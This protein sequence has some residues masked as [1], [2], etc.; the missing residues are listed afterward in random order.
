M[1]L[2]I[3]FQQ[4][5]RILSEMSANEKNVDQSLKRSTKELM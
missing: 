1:Y 5:S 4:Y 3:Y 2:F